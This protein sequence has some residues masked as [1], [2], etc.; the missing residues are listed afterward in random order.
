MPLTASLYGLSDD[1]LCK[2]YH[3][4]TTLIVTFSYIDSILEAGFV[5]SMMASTI[6]L[7]DG[8]DFDLSINTISLKYHII[9]S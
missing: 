8:L 3:K 7:K 6:I 9:N 5:I 2:N 1:P 4:K